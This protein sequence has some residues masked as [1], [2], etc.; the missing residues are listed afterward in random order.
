M[1]FCEVGCDHQPPHASLASHEPT[2]PTDL[3]SESLMVETGE[4]AVERQLAQSSA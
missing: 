3:L 4:A 2:E 1:V